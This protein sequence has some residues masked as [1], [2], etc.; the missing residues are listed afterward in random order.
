MSSHFHVF[1]FIKF[2]SHLL[3]HI[4]SNAVSSAAWV[5]TIVFGM[6]TGVAPKRI[7]TEICC[8]HGSSPPRARKLAKSGE[9][10]SY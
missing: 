9:R 8:V 2:G 5:L 7:A 6:G 4:V 1:L 10:R 3:S